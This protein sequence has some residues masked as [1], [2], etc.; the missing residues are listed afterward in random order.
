MS[1]DEFNGT[2]IMAQLVQSYFGDKPD[3]ELLFL[4]AGTGNEI[5]EV[6][7]FEKS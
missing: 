6:R 1:S 4:P 5:A 2:K 3:A 7:E